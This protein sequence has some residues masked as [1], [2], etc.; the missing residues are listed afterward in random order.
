MTLIA[1]IERDTP[2]SST[3]PSLSEHWKIVGKTGAVTR[4]FEFP[5]YAATSAFLD[6]L[7]AL[8]EETGLYPDLGF[9][10]TYV[11]VTVPDDPNRNVFAARI[12]DVFTE[13]QT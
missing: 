12:N 2:M 10:T 9:G 6:E 8:S 3:A 1:P 13:K 4:R 7:N 11:N 5:N